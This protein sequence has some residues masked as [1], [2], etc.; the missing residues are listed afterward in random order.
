MQ[1][2]RS[3]LVQYSRLNFQPR[4]LI[5]ERQRKIAQRK[6]ADRLDTIKNMLLLGALI[7]CILAAG[8][9][10]AQSIAEGLMLP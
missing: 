7:C 5:T 1:Q 3:H 6:R 8:Y 10:D 9:L 4:P 2:Q